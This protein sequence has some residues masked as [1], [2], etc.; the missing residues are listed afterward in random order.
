MSEFNQEFNREVLTAAEREA[1]PAFKRL[2]GELQQLNFVGYWIDS[3]GDQFFAH[4]QAYSAP[5]AETSRKSSYDVMQRKA[6][7]NAIDAFLCKGRKELFLEELERA[8]RS[9]R[10]TPTKLRLFE[11][12][13]ATEFGVDL[14]TLRAEAAKSKKKEAA[15]E[16][17]SADVLE[18]W[19]KNRVPR[20][21]CSCNGS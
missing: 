18:G 9:R 11:L 21:R 2:A 8:C 6:V 12:R 20:P 15:Q 5:D 16:P 14:K 4:A 17:E 10:I 7:K 13:A 3:G 19:R 1:H